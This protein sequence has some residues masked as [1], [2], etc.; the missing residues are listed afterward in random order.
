MKGKAVARRVQSVE[1]GMEH[2]VSARRDVLA[3]HT[4]ECQHA[5]ITKFVG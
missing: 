2:E 1:R 3:A 4:G 5:D